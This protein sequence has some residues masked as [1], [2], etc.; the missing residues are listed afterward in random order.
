MFIF[1]N[2][3]L[4]LRRWCAAFAAWGGVAGDRTPK[5]VG[6]WPNRAEAPKVGEYA[7]MFR[8]DPVRAPD[9]E[10]G[11]FGTEVSEPGRTSG[12]PGSSA[13]LW[14]NEHLSNDVVLESFYAS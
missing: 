7:R 9:R 8:V 5:D 11:F 3:M 13:L 12:P 2:W 6:R 10:T 4:R 1:V 14:R